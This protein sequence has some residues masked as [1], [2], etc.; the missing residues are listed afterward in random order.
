MPNPFK[1]PLRFGDP[2]QIA[3]IKAMN[4]ENLYCPECYAEHDPDMVEWHRCPKC[5]VL[6]KEGLALER[7]RAAA[8]A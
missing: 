3:A 2:E 6:M 7:R 1:R 5:G 8:N 4:G